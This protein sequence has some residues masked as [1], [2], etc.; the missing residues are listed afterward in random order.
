[1]AA[2]GEDLAYIHD[3][4]F[5]GIAEQ[6]VPVIAANVRPGGVVVDVGCGS[7][8]T[9]RLL[10]D[11]GYEVIGIDQSAA[12]IELAR[13]RAPEA[14]FRVGS[15]VDEPLPA[16][17]GVT[18]IGEVLGYLLDPRAGLG[19]LRRFFSRAHA[20]LRP[21]GALVFDLLGPGRGPGRGYT[22]GDDWAVMAEVEV[23]AA[24][25]NLTRTMVTFRRE[26]ELYRRGEEVHRV[27]LL[28]P[29]EVAAMARRA[30]FRVRVRRAYSGS[31]RF[32]PGHSVYLARRP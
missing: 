15:F 9:A 32:Q 11:A 24:R 4:G 10:T 8:V 19:A 21:D 26:G 28:P 31:E 14:S 16:C 17:D 1:V 23:D 3:A 6:A 18:A 29:A 7:G 22:V 12:M 20:A 2:Y 30:G 13:A 5:T 27:R 25:R